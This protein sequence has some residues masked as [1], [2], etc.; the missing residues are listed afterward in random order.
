MSRTF[1]K[2]A[3]EETNTSHVLDVLVGT[4]ALAGLCPTADFSKDA[5]LGLAWSGKH[6]LFALGVFV[7]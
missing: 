4:L 5:I 1:G 2:W 3:D 6:G 7:F